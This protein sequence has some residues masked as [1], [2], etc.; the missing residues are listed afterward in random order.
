MRIKILGP[1][2][3]IGEKNSYTPSGTKMRQVLALLISNANTVA[4]T[5][6]IAEELWGENPPRSVNTTLQTYIYKLRK[7][8]NREFPEES[9]GDRLVT[10]VPGYRFDVPQDCVDANTFERLARQGR[11]LLNESRVEEALEKLHAATEL[12]SGAVLENVQSLRRL[13]SHAL[14][15]EELRIEVLQMQIVAKIRAGRCHELIP[16]L[17]A[18]SET[19]PLNEWF[20]GQLMFALARSGRRGEALDVYQRLWRTLDDELGLEPSIAMK[21]FQVEILS[22]DEGLHPFVGL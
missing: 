20:H 3:V 7:D 1:L 6:S 13:K 5:E 9:L 22:N 8:L 4:S 17:R 16:E 14:R 18:L 21:R 2:E 10:R 11:T 15:L 19:H 12:W